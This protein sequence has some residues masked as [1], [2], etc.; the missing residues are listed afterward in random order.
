VKID[1]GYIFRDLDNKE[2]SIAGK[3]QT[4][5]VI[6]CSALLSLSENANPAGAD[7]ALRYALAMKIHNNNPV[8]LD[9]DELKLLKDLIGQ[10]FFPLIVGQAW[11]ILEPKGGGS[12]DI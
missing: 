2:I 3:V 9:L 1:T 7:K 6:A 11:E 10:S 12:D 8:E 5:G 4:F